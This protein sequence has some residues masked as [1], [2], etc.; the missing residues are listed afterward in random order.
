MP[1]MSSTVLRDG[2][3]GV[4]GFN[5][6]LS[7]FTSVPASLDLSR[8]GITDFNVAFGGSNI[9]SQGL[10][11]SFQNFMM[12]TK[13]LGL[14]GAYVR[15]IT[16]GQISFEDF[17]SIYGYLVTDLSIRSSQEYGQSKSISIIGKNNND[18]NCD[19]Y[20]FVAYEKRVSINCITGD[21]TFS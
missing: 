11:Y 5:S 12:E 9:Y 4:L 14:D 15:G 18:Y 20:I 16:S 1:L 10:Q 7:P 21:V 3:G 13:N 6:L 2:A 19:L 8:G 17:E